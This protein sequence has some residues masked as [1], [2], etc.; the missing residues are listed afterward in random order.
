MRDTKTRVGHNRGISPVPA[1]LLIVAAVAVVAVYVIASGTLGAASQTQ[2]TEN[3]SITS[4]KINSNTQITFNLKNSGSTE[5]TLSS[6]LVDGNNISVVFVTNPLPAGETIPVI[7][8]DP[9][10][11]WLGSSHTIEVV[12]TDGISAEYTVK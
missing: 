2:T 5:I 6:A 11:M 12:A 7:L 3:L 8:N 4:G 1:A 10:A 9:T